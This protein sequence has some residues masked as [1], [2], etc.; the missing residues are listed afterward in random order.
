MTWSD[1]FVRGSSERSHPKKTHQ[2]LVVLLLWTAAAMFCGVH[3]L[4]AQQGTATFHNPL[5]PA[6]PDPWVTTANGYFYYM[7]TTGDNLTIRRTRDITDLAHAEVKTVWTPPPT[8]PYSKDIWAPELHQ[9]DG[10]W[11]IYF[12]ADDGHNETHR[13]YVIENGS[14]DPLDG[15]WKFR[16]KVGDASDRWAIDASVFEDHGRKYL[17]WSGWEG[18]AD[19]E[20]RIYIAHLKNPWTVD[21]GRTQLSYP[22]YPWEH[23]GDLP[24]RPAVPHVDV[25]E[26]P[27]ILTHGNRIFLVYSGSA[28]WTDYYELGVV[29]AT[30]GT[31]LL[32]LASWTKFDHAFF[33]QDREH[34]VFGPGH[35]GFFRSPDGTED[36]IIY[37]ANSAS[38]QGCG[39]H[40]SPRIQKFIW[41]ADGTP[42]FG[43]PVATDTELAKPSGS[44]PAAGQQP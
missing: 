11:Y 39:E 10:K 16:G 40:R 21:S 18:T 20:Q 7:N 9:L 15:T 26:G 30:S 2:R 4:P 44:F 14:A 22:E 24:E 29:E 27:E 1:R 6:G 5:L 33:K 32:S 38:G 37:H 13:I 12:A 19:G 34:H 31:D 23:V 43:K 25:N 17:L 42:D 35:N 36:W 41:N 28:C 3:G 8:G